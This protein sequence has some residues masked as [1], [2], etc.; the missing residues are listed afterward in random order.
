MLLLTFVMF[1]IPENGE[2]RAAWK[3]FWFFGSILPRE[4]ISHGVLEYKISSSTIWNRCS[5]VGKDFCHHSPSTA[6]WFVQDLYI[7]SSLVMNMSVIHC[8][9][10]YQFT[11]R[12]CWWGP[13]FYIRATLLPG[14]TVFLWCLESS[15][16]LAPFEIGYNVEG[17]SSPQTTSRWRLEA[18]NQTVIQALW[19]SDLRK[20]Q[21]LCKL[22][23]KLVTA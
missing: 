6:V 13:F 15:A 16:F 21:Q 17:M 19:I 20:G 5:W 7:L 2:R 4:L 3:G 12:R 10:S 23:L 22:I 8:M 1:V 14:L 11:F 18:D 9:S